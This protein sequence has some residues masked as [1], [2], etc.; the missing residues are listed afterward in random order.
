MK[1]RFLSDS[2]KNTPSTGGRGSRMHAGTKAFALV[3][4]AGLIIPMATACKKKNKGSDGKNSKNSAEYVEESDLYFSDTSI[5]L[6]IDFQADSTREAQSTDVWD[7]LIGN[8][9]IYVPYYITYKATEEEADFMENCN[10]ND[11]EQLKKYYEISQALWESGFVI[12]NMQGET[13]S[14]IKCDVYENIGNLHVLNDGRLVADYSE[15]VPET[16]EYLHKIYIMD[17]N[18]EKLSQIDVDLDQGDGFEVFS[19]GDGSMVLRPSF[20]SKLIIIDENGKVTGETTYKHD[21]ETICTFEG[22]TYLLTQK[23]KYTE[24]EVQIQNFVQEIDV[25]S[26]KLGDQIEIASDAPYRF[27]EGNALYCQ[28]EGGLYT[29]DLL[30]GTS[31]K[32][33]GPENLD[34]NFDSVQDL[35]ICENGDIDYTLSRQ[36]GE[37]EMSEREMTLVHLHR[38]EK[39]PY[40]G[41]R[42][43]YLCSCMDSVYDVQKMVVA[44][45]KR[46]ES[47]ARIVTYVQTADTSEGFAKAQSTAADDLLLAMK[48][49]NGPDV[50]LNCAEYGQFNSDEILVDLNTYMDGETGIDRDKYFDN[51]FRAFEANGKLYQ[52]PILVSMVGFNADPKVLGNVDSWNLSDFDQKIG[53]IGGDV[54]PATGH[55]MDSMFVSESTT[56]LRGFLY[57]DMDHYVDYSKRECYFDS[58][59]FRKVLEM[60]KKYGDLMTTDQFTALQEEYDSMEDDHRQESLMMQDGVC[61]L[62]TFYISNLTSFSEYADLCNNDPLFIGWPSTESSGMTAVADVSVGISAF[63]KCKDEAWDFVSYLLSEEAQMILV[64]N[65]NRYIYLNRAV[66]DA[67]IQ[68][69]IQGYKDKVKYYTEELEDP[70]MASRVSVADEATASR[71]LSVIERIGASLMKNPAIMDIVLEE[72]KPYFAGQQSAENVSKSIQ[73]RVTTL[74]QETK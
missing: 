16:Q 47:K 66:E 44:Y 19:L 9:K 34:I 8:D 1:F 60:S 7:A 74:L 14:K 36:I 2:N 59:D 17:E 68:A 37:G 58:D 45:N 3:L 52:L 21:F 29:Y 73:N 41:R 69:S 31:E 6:N 32:V 61:A 43:V 67:D 24:T 4:C 35:R 38:E 50:L 57:N 28:Y 26:G 53:A 40:A 23:A 71:F 56:L 51:I 25:K 48:S 49:G 72:S 22:K 11:D 46:P 13:I 64:E 70:E 33:F 54:Y 42:I 55:F 15:F 20:G 27:Y 65:V 18:G 10:Y 12:L 62:S 39:N 5:D 30:K 63:S